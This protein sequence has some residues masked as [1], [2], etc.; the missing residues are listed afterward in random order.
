MKQSMLAAAFALA[1]PTATYAQDRMQME[2]QN[3]GEICIQLN[4]TAQFCYAADAESPTLSSNGIDYVIIPGRVEDG[5]AR[6]NDCAGFFDG[7]D[8][9]PA[10]V[11]CF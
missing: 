9:I 10:H 7:Q 5:R 2:P 4:T 3:D 8:D 6:Y 1:L 11:E